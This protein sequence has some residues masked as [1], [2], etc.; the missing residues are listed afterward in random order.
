MGEAPASHP[1]SPAMRW[2]L[3]AILAAATWWAFAEVGDNRSILLDDLTYVYEN[4]QVLAGLTWEGTRWAFTTVA[5]ANWHP[6]TWLSHMLDVELFG[7]DPGR[8]HL[9]NLAFH[10]ANALLVFFLVLR[11]TGATWR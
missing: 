11:W 6:L 1:S 8:H 2:L 3:A 5:G 9:V 7:A 4:P 10:V